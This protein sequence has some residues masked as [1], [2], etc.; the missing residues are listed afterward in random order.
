MDETRKRHLL[1][2]EKT[3]GECFKFQKQFHLD[4]LNS[5]LKN[6]I[7]YFDEAKT[8]KEREK[9]F[10]SY[11]TTNL[12]IHKDD[13]R[14]LLIYGCEEERKKFEAMSLYEQ[15]MYLHDD[16]LKYKRHFTIFSSGKMVNIKIDDIIPSKHMMN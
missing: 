5:F 10:T 3:G 16:V 1:E 11:V 4:F 12:D 15:A 2:I 13:F 6:I 8:D 7:K 9:I 14:D